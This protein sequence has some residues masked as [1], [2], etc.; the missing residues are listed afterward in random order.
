MNHIPFSE[1]R[2]ERLLLRK[3]VESDWEM[4]SYLR[5]DKEVNKLVKRPD[6]PT[7]EKAIDFIEKT[8][9]RIDTG[10]IYYWCISLKTHPE[11]IGSI[12]LW[13][14]CEDRKIAETGYDLSPEYQGKGI[15][16]EAMQSV[17]EFGF[18]TLRLEMIEAYTHH[19]N[20]PSKNLLLR[21][22]FILNKKRKD[23]DNKDNTIYEKVFNSSIA[24]GRRDHQ[25]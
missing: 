12:C 15:M 6:A 3:P 4:I 19:K 13:N 2:T 23:S 25:K 5:T 8:V 7:K 16:Q 11:M 17:L 24:T 10:N 21:N 14:F 18:I 1:L 22:N 20:E 9:V